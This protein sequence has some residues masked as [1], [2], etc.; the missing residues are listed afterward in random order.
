ML[1]Y[2]FFP[3]SIFLNSWPTF[4]LWYLFVKIRPYR[5]ICDLQSKT[6][7]T[8]FPTPSY[9]SPPTRDFKHSI[10]EQ[11]FGPNLAWIAERG[12]FHAVFPVIFS[13]FRTPI[14]SARSLYMKVSYSQCAVVEWETGRV[15]LMQWFEILFCKCSWHFLNSRSIIRN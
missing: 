3:S 15:G 14:P 10:L 8:S 7:T 11:L 12:L 13:N 4:W 6:E 1:S 2:L 9:W 5:S